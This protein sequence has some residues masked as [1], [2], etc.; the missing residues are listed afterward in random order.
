M[1][2][3]SEAASTTQWVDK[4][5]GAVSREYLLQYFTDREVQKAVRL[6]Q[7]GE[8]RLRIVSDRGPTLFYFSTFRNG[9]FGYAE[10]CITPTSSNE[11]N[12]FYK[13]TLRY[14]CCC[15]NAPLGQFKIQ[16]QAVYDAR[17]GPS[18]WIF[19]DDGINIPPPVVEE[20]RLTCKE[21][22]ILGL[23]MLQR[24]QH[25]EQPLHNE[26][27]PVILSSKRRRRRKWSKVGIDP[28]NVNVEQVPR[29]HPRRSDE[30]IAGCVASK[31]I[32][33]LRKETEAPRYSYQP[34]SE[35]KYPGRPGEL[36]DDVRLWVKEDLLLHGTG[37]TSAICWANKFYSSCMHY[38]LRNRGLKCEGNDRAADIA[39]CI[40]MIVNELCAPGSPDTLGNM[41]YVGFARV[42]HS[43][44]EMRGAGQD[45]LEKFSKLIASELRKPLPDLPNEEPIYNPAA[46]ISLLWNE[47]YENLCRDLGLNNLIRFGKPTTVYRLWDADR[48]AY[49]YAIPLKSVCPDRANSDADDGHIPADIKSF[50]YR[51]CG[52]LDESATQC[53]HMQANA[54]CGMDWVYWSQLQ[55]LA[56]SDGL[57]NLI[58][59]ASRHN[60]ESGHNRRLRFGD[61]R[62]EP[63]G[64]E[65]YEIMDWSKGFDTLCDKAVNFTFDRGDEKYPIAT[66]DWPIS[67]LAI[68]EDDVAI[69]KVNC[70]LVFIWV[71][72][73]KE[74]HWAW[75]SDHPIRNAGQR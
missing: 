28:D 58:I 20:L 44:S 57:K 60:P 55:F 71:R 27:S 31:I 36:G 68:M 65:I 10:I 32:K 6:A 19:G 64:L 50:S 41:I 22:A 42:N 16:H 54:A 63:S 61:D 8:Q 70:P 53:V 52:T 21:K 40:N 7:K 34:V 69:R 25:T 15:D 45:R 56:I 72:F 74:E 1:A 39:Y 13:P 30:A 73:Y 43:M 51:E 47:P 18:Q 62:E 9:H 29:K 11:R 5:E 2:Q 35:I 46:V 59:D 14:T 75:L 38:I 3:D 4:A 48:C 26:S 49:T 24:A 66:K 67:T 33:A 37:S 23:E 17:I 12:P